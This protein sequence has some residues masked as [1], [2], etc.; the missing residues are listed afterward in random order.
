MALEELTCT[1]HL[2]Q[3]IEEAWHGVDSGGMQR[4]GHKVLRQKGM[5]TNRGSM[6]RCMQ[7]G[8]E[9]YTWMFNILPPFR[10]REEA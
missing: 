1:H 3:E 5:Q 10:N 9:F 4:G 7:K 8:G 6:A 2:E